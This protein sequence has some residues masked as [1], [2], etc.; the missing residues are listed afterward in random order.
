MSSQS[1]GVPANFAVQ[2]TVVGNGPIAKT[3]D[4]L[5]VNYTG[6]LENGTVFDTSIGGTP[7][8]FTLGAGEVIVGWDLGLQGMQAGGKRT[9]VIPPEMAYGSRDYGP[10]PGNST[11]RFDVELL[12]ITPA[13]SSATE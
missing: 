2:D 7:F 3:G 4:R 9:L 12:S 11:L 1:S 8:S 6:R 5:T 10:I 13:D